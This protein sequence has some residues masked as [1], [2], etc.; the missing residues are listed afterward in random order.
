MAGPANVSECE[1]KC[2]PQ[3]VKHEEM[4]LE[5][6]KKDYADF[7]KAGLEVT[8]LIIFIIVVSIGLALFML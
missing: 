6:R 1:C 7:K 5:N 2:P 4:T 8:C 3:V